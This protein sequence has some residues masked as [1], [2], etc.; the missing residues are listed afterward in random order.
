LTVRGDVVPLP[1]GVDLTAYRV[2][3]EALTNARRHAPG[4]EVD[5]EIGYGDGAVRVRVR[6]NG[7]GPAG[8]GNDGHG[9]VGMHERVSMVGGTLRLGPAHGGGFAVDAVLPI[10]EPPA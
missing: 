9:L 4:A 10:G 3:Q 2:V 5:I 8:A 1:P 6:D 7:P